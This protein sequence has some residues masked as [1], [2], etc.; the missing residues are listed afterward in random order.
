MSAISNE[1]IAKEIIKSEEKLLEIE[2]D[3]HFVTHGKPD[4]QNV[5]K[6]SATPLNKLKSMGESIETIALA[7]D[8]QCMTSKYNHI[9]IS[10]EPE[11]SN[12]LTPMIQFCR[13]T[14]LLHHDPPQQQLFL[15]CNTC[16]Y[17]IMYDEIR[18]QY[19]RL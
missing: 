4:S 18:Q 15:S 3:L 17:Q 8:Y 14:V 7:Y 10:V 13:K 9:A 19:E 1:W 11:E 6:I 16:P 12:L 5:S 2:H